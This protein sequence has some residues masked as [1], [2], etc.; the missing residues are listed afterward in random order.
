MTAIIIIWQE[1]GYTK[2]DSSQ[3]RVITHL[4]VPL[5]HFLYVRLLTSCLSPC[6]PSSAAA[7]HTIIL[8]LLPCITP[9]S[10]ARARADEQLWKDAGRRAAR[11][12]RTWW[13]RR[14]ISFPGF[15]SPRFISTSSISNTC[16]FLFWAVVRR[17]FFLWHTSVKHRC[18]TSSGMESER[19]HVIGDIPPQW[20]ASLPSSSA[21]NIR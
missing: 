11:N 12:R 15:R 10:E 16:Y 19:G 14:G 21:L 1:E 9:F 20:C 3:L 13:K 4:P 2:I 5:S 8:A 18:S 7:L 17:W 6:I